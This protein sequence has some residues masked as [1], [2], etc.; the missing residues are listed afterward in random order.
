MLILTEL[1]L[2][3]HLLLFVLNLAPISLILLSSCN[4]RDS[5]HLVQPP[6]GSALNLDQAA[7]AFVQVGSENFQGW[8]SHS[9]FYHLIS[10]FL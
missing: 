10:M 1:C 6:A 4:E 3:N 7:Q 9:L 2:K 5:G 8:K